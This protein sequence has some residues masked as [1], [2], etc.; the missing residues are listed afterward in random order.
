VTE[1]DAYGALERRLGPALAANRPGSDV[2]HVLIALPSYSVSESLLSHYGDRIPSLEHRYLG[3][4]L[5]PARVPSCEI[6]Y[7]SSRRPEQ[8]AIDYYPALLPPERRTQVEGRI[9]IMEWNDGTPRSVAARLVSRPDLIADLRTMIAGRPALIEPWNV[10]E[11]EVA[12]ALALDVPINGTRPELRPIAFKSAGRRL[13]AEAGVSVP[14]GREDVRTVDDVIEAVLAI[15]AE[16]PDAPGVVIKHDDSGAGDGN[17]VI[18]LAPLEDAADP[19]AWLRGTI[20]NLPDWYRQD[21]ALGGIV[22]ERVVGTRFTSPSAQADIRPDGEVVVLATH[23]QVLGGEGGQVYLGCR[24]P[25]HPAYA[26]RLA[27]AAR[28]VGEQLARRG[29]LG[30]FSV[31]FVA[32]GDDA[33]RWRIDA[34]EI[35]LRK[36]GTTHPYSAL[37][38]LVPGRYATDEGRWIADDGTS[39]AYS[40]TD[41]LVDEAWLGLPVPAVID[42]VA[43]AGLGF[44]HRTRTGVVLH[45]LS[46]LAIDGRLGLTAIGRTADEAISL[47]EGVR[48]TLDGL[49]TGGP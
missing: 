49:A 16:H 7:I 8:A 40:A 10:T 28:A 39:R 19:I 46:G 29:A 27:D 24:F 17:V 47:H 11:H 14:L 45:M 9:R 31:D 35:N 32:A 33:G 12:L 26:P 20:A 23:E 15:R 2:D 36:G 6:V 34:I 4:I 41:N 5:I 22:E 30:R 18:D 42:A 1:A 25:A 3:A 13:L 21:L 37:R 44:D 43:G 48:A 38:N